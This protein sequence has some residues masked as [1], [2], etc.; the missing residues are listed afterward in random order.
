[1]EYVIVGIIGAVAV[2]G[3][4]AYRYKPED[5]SRFDEPRAVPVIHDDEVSPEH[6]SVVDKLNEF[7][8]HASTDVQ[9]SRKQ[10]EDLFY[11]DVDAQ[12]TAVDV[13][14]IPAEWVLAQGADPNL[15]LLYLHGGAFRVGSPKSHRYITHQ[16]SKRCGLAVLAVDYRMQPE[17]KTVHCHEDARKAYAWIL[18]N[19]PDG[20]DGASTLKSLF[21]AG[22]SAG[23][24]MTLSVIAW[25][26]DQ[27]LRA[28]DGAI[29]F[30]PLTD[31]TLSSPTWKS[32]A[33]TDPFLGPG[34]GRLLKVPRFVI[35][36]SMRKTS[37]AAVNDPVLSPLLGDL[38]GLPKTLV[39]V[40]RDEMLYG[41]AQRYANKA[42][43]HGSDVTLQV[44]P[45][46]VHVFQGFPELPETHDALSRVSDFV[47]A[48]LGSNESEERAAG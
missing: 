17:F 48:Q 31:A 8:R 40:G 13:A 43:A 45:K 15:R 11:Q 10:L 1:M 26:R 46:M 21:V 35:A 39:Q 33:A 3:L 25:A 2:L 20:A 16:L 24:N 27:R 5:H 34:I 32:N 41:D 9:V 18:E 37:G 47:K 12:I 14:G 6:D 22:D 7:A 44:W 42:N 23:G 30:A 19:G 29:A 36:L 4:L 28:V 38:S